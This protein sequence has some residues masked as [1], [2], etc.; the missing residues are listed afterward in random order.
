MQIERVCFRYNKDSGSNHIGKA[1]LLL[2]STDTSFTRI[3]I[4]ITVQ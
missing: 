1:S 3:G 4:D 2:E